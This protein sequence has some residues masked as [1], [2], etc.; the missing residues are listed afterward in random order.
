METVEPGAHQQL[1]FW[2]TVKKD[3]VYP[4]RVTE[5]AGVSLLTM[6]LNI[7]DENRTTRF[8]CRKLTNVRFDESPGKQALTYELTDIYAYAYVFDVRDQPPE[9]SI[10]VCR[11]ENNQLYAVA[12][13]TRHDGGNPL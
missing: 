9:G 3:G 10:L 11:W 6:S 2:I 12:N 5:D 4:N 13:D 7:A 1:E 8:Y